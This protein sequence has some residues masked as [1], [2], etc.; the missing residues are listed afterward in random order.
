LFFQGFVATQVIQDSLWAGNA[1]Q[2]L[3]RGIP[4]LSHAIDHLLFKSGARM[5]GSA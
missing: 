4:D 5:M 3:W 2:V 1:A